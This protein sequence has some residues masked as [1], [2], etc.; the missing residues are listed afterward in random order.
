MRLF[1]RLLLPALAIVALA[2]MAAA[3]ALARV[4][5]ERQPDLSLMV[6]PSLAPALAVKA[7]RLIA[8]SGTGQDRAKLAE[9]RRLAQRALRAAPLNPEALRTLAV[10]G[11]QN[12]D[13]W[14]SLIATALRVSRRDIGSQLL[15]I[16]LDVARNDVGATLRHY[17]QALRV[18]PSI[19]PTLYPVLL[20][21]TDDP[22]LLGSIRR[23]VSTDRP[24]LP[25]LSGWVVENPRYLTRFTRLVEALPPRSEAMSLAYGGPMIDG[26]VAQERLSDAYVNYRAYRRAMLLKPR[27]AHRP[28]RPFEWTSLDNF[29]TGSDRVSDRA[30]AFTIF[31]DR[32]ANGEILSRL[33]R[34]AP[35]T[36]RLSSA[37]NSVEGGGAHLQTQISC[38]GGGAPT[39][40][41]SNEIPVSQRSIAMNFTV[42]AGRCPFQWVRLHVRAG[43][44][45]FRAQLERLSLNRVD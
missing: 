12:V 16:E 34:L 19:G 32:G 37:L 6:M 15:Q 3:Y 14:R 23:F 1:T 39:S 4:V 33:T 18:T 41:L 44:E 43:D 2:G 10:T 21:A 27:E 9:A 29:E 30:D 24:W 5:E 20:T 42:P 11:P 35:G 22:A 45:T 31:A 13:A 40:L 25:R 38:A 28:L 8:D 26:L 36:Y 17:D 7:D